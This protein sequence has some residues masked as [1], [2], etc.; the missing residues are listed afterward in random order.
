MMTTKKQ[1]DWKLSAIA[2]GCLTILQL[3]SMYYGLNGTI[4][5]IV[6]SLIALIVGVQLPQFKTK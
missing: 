3:A 2:V 4:R 5:T 1:I 6:F